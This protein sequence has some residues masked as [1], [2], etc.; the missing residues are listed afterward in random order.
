M[1]RNLRHGRYAERTQLGICRPKGFGRSEEEGPQVLRPFLA[2]PLHFPESRVRAICDLRSLSR[3]VFLDEESRC[4]EAANPA[5]A[6]GLQLEPQ[7]SRAVL[8]SLRASTDACPI[9][10]RK[11]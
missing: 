6:R 2:P 10:S 5:R 11:P 8:G 9:R 7:A 1:R 4:L 3:E